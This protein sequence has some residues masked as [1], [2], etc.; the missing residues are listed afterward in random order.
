MVPCVFGMLENIQTIINPIDN[1]VVISV[2]LSENSAL[3]AGKPHLTS[4]H[5]F[6]QG[7]RFKINLRICAL[8][9][10]AQRIVIVS[11]NYSFR[12]PPSSCKS[13]RMNKRIHQPIAGPVGYGGA[14]DLFEGVGVAAIEPAAVGV[15]DSL[16]HL[17]ALRLRPHDIHQ[18]HIRT[19]HA[20]TCM[21]VVDYVG[22]HVH[23]FAADGVECTRVPR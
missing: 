5:R 20:L 4:R 8:P 23:H 21:A 1:V 18:A 9:P 13:L 16:E 11:S 6:R 14:G 17:Q 12:S 19:L 15:L 10:Q 2:P 22:S 3:V 7:R